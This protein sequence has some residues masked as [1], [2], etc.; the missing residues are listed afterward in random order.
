MRSITSRKSS[1]SLMPTR[2]RQSLNSWSRTPAAVT[3]SVRSATGNSPNCCETIS[4]C[5]VI[6]M[7]PW[8]VP[9][10]SAASAR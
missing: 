8:V 3:S 9:G 6:L 4:P 2:L 10:G 7:R 1:T 5:S